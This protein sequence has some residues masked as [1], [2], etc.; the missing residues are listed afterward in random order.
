M[1]MEPVLFTVA[2]QLKCPKM[3][4]WIKKTL[5]SWKLRRWCYGQVWD[6]EVSSWA[7]LFAPCSCLDHSESEHD[8]GV[9]MIRAEINNTNK[10]SNNN[11]PVTEVGRT[12]CWIPLS[13]I[14]GWH[15]VVWGPEM[16]PHKGGYYHGKLIF[17]QRIFLHTFCI[18]MITPGFHLHMWNPAWSFSTILTGPW[19]GEGLYTGRCKDIELHEKATGCIKFIV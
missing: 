13:N 1:H 16:I 14:L 4:N 5:V 18:Y 9:Y 15:Y 8:G 3:D 2:K 19:A 11:N 6:G 17:S 7:L 12:L 10:S